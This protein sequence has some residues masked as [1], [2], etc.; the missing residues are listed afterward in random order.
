MPALKKVQEQ[1]ESVAA[2][3]RERLLDAAEE[4]F[5]DFGFNGVSVRQ[6]VEKAA[7]NLGAIPY[8]F[9][10]KENLFK[11]VI[12]RR[13]LPLQA[14]R[15]S[16]MQEL[17]SDDEDVTLEDVVFALLEPAFRANRANRSFR[18]LLGRASMD[19]AP[20]VRKLMDEIY[21]RDFMLVPKTLRDAL[22]EIGSEEFFWKLNCF[23]GVMLFVQ[24]DI[25]KIQT[26]AGQEFDT[27]RPDIALKHVVPFLAAGLRSQT[28]ESRP[29]PSRR[30]RPR[31]NRR[32]REKK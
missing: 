9:G 30:I 15:E 32:T 3:S 8:H 20:E 2:S 12:L 7:V 17:I 21:T 14:E 5:A 6:I 18:R 28:M 19:P 26:I 11:S 27:S 24:A 29:D 13:V 22:P 4:L 16:L 25:G 23:Y 1:P 10:T 31:Q